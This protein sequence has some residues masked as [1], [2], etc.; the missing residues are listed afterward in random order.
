MRFAL[1][2]LILAGSVLA[3]CASGGPSYSP[4]PP[5]APVLLASGDA[6]SP[7]EVIGDVE[8]RGRTAA[9]ATERLRERA[10][11]RGADGVVYVRYETLGS[12]T[13]VYGTAVRRL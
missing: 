11:S 6:E 10:R 7:Y 4:L 1:F 5:G 3:G 12:E 2:L 9:Q 13:R 8:G